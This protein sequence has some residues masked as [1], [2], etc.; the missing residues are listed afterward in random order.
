[1]L[2]LLPLMKSDLQGQRFVVF[3]ACLPSIS[4]LT[5][6][7]LTGP[8]VGLWDQDTQLLACGTFSR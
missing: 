5:K 3:A 4:V 2:L 6:Y 8:Q 1:M 7:Y